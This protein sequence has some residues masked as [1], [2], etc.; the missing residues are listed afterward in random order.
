MEMMGRERE[1]YITIHNFIYIPAFETSF[2]ESFPI[3]QYFTHISCTKGL[4]SVILVAHR[5]NPDIS[6]LLYRETPM[7]GPPIF[8]GELENVKG[9][10]SMYLLLIKYWTD[11]TGH[12]QYTITRKCLRLKCPQCSWLED[13]IPGVLECSW[14][15]STW[16]CVLLIYMLKLHVWEHFLTTEL[17]ADSPISLK[18]CGKSL[19]GNILGEKKNPIFKLAHI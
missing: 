12:R 5:N 10:D 13:Q 19:G 17:R 8:Q 11:E 1:V 6:T 2:K 9:T 16:E 7:Q 15:H 18:S 4:P 14:S 3:I